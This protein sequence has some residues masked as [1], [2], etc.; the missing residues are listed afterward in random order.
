MCLTI[1]RS[2]LLYKARRFVGGREAEGV[3]LRRGEGTCWSGLLQDSLSK[4]VN[5]GRI[6]L[7]RSPRSSRRSEGLSWSSAQL[8]TVVSQVVERSSTNHCTKYKQ[9]QSARIV[10]FHEQVA[11]QV[12]KGH[13]TNFLSHHHPRVLTLLF[14]NSSSSLTPSFPPSVRGIPTPCQT[15]CDSTDPIPGRGDV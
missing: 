14:V 8:E 15:R 13:V 3:I 4:R 1:E 11:F 2:R 7:E 5:S 10:G 12:V 6:L 9:S